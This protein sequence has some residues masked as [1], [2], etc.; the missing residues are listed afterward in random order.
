[1]RRRFSQDFLLSA[2]YTFS[3]ILTD[4]AG[5]TTEISPLTT[6][7]NSQIDKQRPSYDIPHVFNLTGVYEL[8]F[9]PGRRFLS[10]SSGL[11]SRLVEGWNISTIVRVTAGTS[12]SMLSGMGTF[13]QR[14]G[15]TT[16]VLP[17][18][19]SFNELQQYLGVFKTGGGVFTIDPNA[20]FMRITYDAA[21]RVSRSE[22]DTKQLQSPVAGQL[23]ELPL[24]AFR[25]PFQLAQ[26]DIAFFKQTRIWESVNFEFRAEL[27][28]AFNHPIFSLPGSLTTSSTQFGVITSAG[29]RS[30]QLSARV[31]F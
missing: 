18:G 12:L 16:I 27:F 21:G 5:S 6:F 9:G 30:I 20:P 3:K 10:G 31:N 7:R 11:V 4:F 22:V 2:N 19:L 26:A 8:P 17:D 23:G 29:S 28:N 14:T 25:L 13:N 24:G 15:S 1:V